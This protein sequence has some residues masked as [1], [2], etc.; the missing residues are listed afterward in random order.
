MDAE[1]SS[2]A[3][4]Y[5]RAAGAIPQW[6]TKLPNIRCRE[7]SDQEKAISEMLEEKRDEKQSA[8]TEICKIPG[9]SK[10]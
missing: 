4:P 8:R 1:Y 9:S 6:R 7:P 5:T 10:R 3:A 2:G